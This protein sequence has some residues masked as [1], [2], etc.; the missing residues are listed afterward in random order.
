MTRDKLCIS[1]ETFV[2]DFLSYF[3]SFRIIYDYDSEYFINK[4]TVFRLVV[5]VTLYIYIFCI[6][7]FG[8]SVLCEA[9][10][11]VGNMGRIHVI[12]T[13]IVSLFMYVLNK[14]IVTVENFL[15]FCSTIKVY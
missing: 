13:I 11:T 15:L 9:I 6:I 10:G 12:T 5:K 14:I 4:W 8:N 2:V 3:H 7:T 1:K